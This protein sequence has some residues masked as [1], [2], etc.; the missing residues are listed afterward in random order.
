MFSRGS[1]PGGLLFP[2]A[3]STVLAGCA[4]TPAAS[5]VQVMPGPGKSFTVFQADND[6]CKSFAA[7]QV[8]GQAE[9]ANQRSVGTAL[10]TTVL[11]AGLGAA[12]GGL[13][14]NA[15]GGAAV[16]A[17]AGAGGGAVI[18][19]S[20]SANDQAGIQ[21]QYDIAFSQCMYS[22][23]ELVPGFAPVVAYGGAAPSVAAD[24]TVRATQVELN[25]LGYL[26]AAADGVAGSRTQSAISS[27]EQANG[28]PVD[29]A[30]SPGL[31]AKLQA[32]PSHAATVTASAPSGWVAPTASASN[33]A[34]SGWVAPAGSSTPA[35]TTAAAPAAAW[36]APAKTQ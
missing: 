15:G 6:S 17:A 18:G 9:A 22:K 20:S 32:T 7:Q 4:A 23:G 35:P 34:S 2:A 27:F 16:G 13:V 1:I 21:Q 28:L 31:L 25:R 12:T 8:Q 29:G 10:L 19:G 30:A 11:G 24:P 26:H 14:G 3:L 33:S 36:V 5:T